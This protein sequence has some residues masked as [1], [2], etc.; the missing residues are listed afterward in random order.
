MKTLMRLGIALLITFGGRT[1]TSTALPLRADDG[2]PPQTTIVSVDAT[3]TNDFDCSFPL[4]E[5]VTGAY[6]DIL[7]FDS[8]GTL[9]REFI[10][11]QYRGPLTVS[12]TNLAMGTSLTSHEAS[13]L[14]ID[15]NPDGSFRKL[16]NQGLTFHVTVPGTGTL[17]L[18]V[19][20]IV[21]ERGHGVT[22]EAGPHQEFNG[23]TAAFCTYLE[24]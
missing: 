13:T 22:F 23:D 16:S 19:G 4:Q 6:R 11:P 17:L 20:R 24:H 1:P 21:I 2:R 5:Q 12:W 9:T 10:S 7:Y 15:Y 3:F 14:I 8:N 18:D